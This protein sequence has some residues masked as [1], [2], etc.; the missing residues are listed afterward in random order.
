MRAQYSAT[1][2]LLFIAFNL[3]TVQAA[4]SYLGIR[5]SNL[6]P[7]WQPTVSAPFDPNALLQR[8]ASE[9]VFKGGCL[10]F[11]DAAPSSTASEDCFFLNIWMPGSRNLSNVSCDP[12]FGGCNL[13]VI[14]WIYGGGFQTGTAKFDF[15]VTDDD[16]S[17]YGIS[18]LVNGADFAVQG[19]LAINGVVRISDIVP[20]CTV[21][22]FL[23][24][25]FFVV[26][27]Q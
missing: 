6:P 25:S 2:A 20:L 18:N 8:N 23:H 14:F 21:L 15:T 12:L 13:P 9:N 7:R 27:T 22:V 24:C 11:S 16:G 4:Q 10:Q 1:T 19:A 17:T 5:Y 26:F 3:H